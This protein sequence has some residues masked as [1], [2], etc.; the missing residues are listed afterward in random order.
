[1]TINSSIQIVAWWYWPPEYL[2]RSVNLPISKDILPI[3]AKPKEAPKE[4]IKKYIPN[5]VILPKFPLCSL[6]KKKYSKPVMVPTK[7]IRLLKCDCPSRLKREAQFL[8]W[9]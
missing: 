1:M 7:I 4:I 8:L 6:E 9:A 3:T 2:I 5:L